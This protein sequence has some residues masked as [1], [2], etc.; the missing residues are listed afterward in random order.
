MQKIIIASGPVI[1][2]AGKVLLNK[3]SEDDF[4]KFCGGRVEN[5]EEGLVD[6]A[7]REVKEEMGIDIEIIN[8]SPFILYVKKEKDGGAIDVLLVHYLA[9]RIGEIISGSDVREWEWFDLKNLPEN[10]APNIVPTLEHFG[11]LGGERI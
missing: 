11:L 7:R 10:L 6:T 1:V 5:F 2:E 3:S 9:K 8:E 4:W